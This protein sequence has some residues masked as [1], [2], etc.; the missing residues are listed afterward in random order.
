[1]AFIRSPTRDTRS[2]SVN[3][4]SGCAA[5]VIVVSQ[6][7]DAPRDVC[8]PRP[9]PKVVPGPDPLAGGQIARDGLV[10]TAAALTP[11]ILERRVVD[12]QV[13]GAQQSR[14]A[15]VVALGPL[16]LDDDG[17]LLGERGGAGCA[18]GPARCLIRRQRDA[19]EQSRAAPTVSASDSTAPPAGR[20]TS[21][22]RRSGRVPALYSA[23]PQGAQPSASPAWPDARFVGAAATERKPRGRATRAWPG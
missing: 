10:E 21:P 3:T 14:E 18:C 7:P 1:M 6:V 2:A 20:R 16:A 15:A 23:A 11:D 8:A 12:R 5:H 22:S 19:A 4:R 17:D 13:C 9:V